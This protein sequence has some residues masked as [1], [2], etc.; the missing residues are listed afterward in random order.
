MAL[1]IGKTERYIHDVL[2]SKGAMFFMDLDPVDYKTPDEAVKVGVA[3]AENGADI[4]LIG[5]STGAQGDLLDYVTKN[6]KDKIGGSVPIVLF[7]GNI[8]TLTKHADAVYFMSLLNARNPYWLI[9]AHMLSAGIVKGMGIEALPTGYIVVAPGGTVGWVAD[10]NLV[11]REK[12]KIAASLALA[13]EYLGQRLIVTDA[14]ANPQL[15]GYGHVPLEMIRMVRSAISVPYVVGG[16]IRTEQELRNVISAGADAVQIGT[17]LEK[18]DGAK[19]LV[20]AFAKA[21]KEEGAKKLKK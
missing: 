9:Q 6:I 20:K 11:P 10:A 7:P 8:A 2:E 5:G 16:G 3:S 18:T 21:V 13:G 15:M 17:A 1:K 19:N 14:G 4:I 12:P